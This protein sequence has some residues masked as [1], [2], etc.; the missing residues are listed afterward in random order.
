MI[1]PRP[2][3]YTALPGEFVLP[4]ALHLAVGPGAEH[5]ADL[6]ADYLGPDRARVDSGPFIALRLNRNAHD[7]PLGYD[8]HIQPQQVTLTA[9]AENGLFNG[10]QTLRQLLPPQALV[11]RGAPAGV[12]RWPACHVRDAPRLPWRGVMLDVARHWMPIEFLH[13][14]VDEIALHKLNILH[15]H[16]TD[17]QGWRVE[18]DGLPLLTEIGSHRPESMVGRAGS[19]VFD[20]TPHSGYYTRAQLTVLVEYA[21]RRGV[22]V[23]P[24]IGMPGHARAAVA[25]YPAI[26][27]HP[28]RPLP[29]WTSWGIS[30]DSLGVHDQALDFCR[31]VLSEIIDIFPSHHIH[32]G[33]DECPTIQWTTAPTALDRA[34][35]LG[36]SDTSQLLGWF[37]RQMHQY[38][39]DRSRRA[40]CWNDS[41]AIGDLDPAM[42]ATAWLK[43]EHATEAVARGHQVIMAPHER[44][45]LDYRQSN[46][47]GEPPAPDDRVLTLAA[48]YSFNPLPDGLTAVGPAALE[49][50][51]GGPGILGTQAQIWTECAPTPEVVRHLAYP[52]LCALAEG[53]WSDHHRDFAEFTNRLRHHMQRLHAIGALPAARPPGWADAVSAASR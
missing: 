50:G 30:E 38:L 53:A 9:A 24:E 4:A 11:R 18:I 12:W 19:T 15:L 10:V 43:P 44:T 21:A 8:L 14:F 27:N 41:V 28:R 32:I 48:A 40:V 2:V 17:D 33:G 47:P 29:V 25:A 37:L 20:G 26:G 52:R 49:S 36:L 45:Y 16:L 34:A 13:Q 46:H 3:E 6:L 22:T 31:Q 35:Q 5:A 42:V 39:A 1:I 51:R 23:V 7:H